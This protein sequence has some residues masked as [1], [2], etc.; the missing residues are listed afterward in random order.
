MKVEIF[1][2]TE[3]AVHY[4]NFQNKTGKENKLRI[5]V[6]KTNLEMLLKLMNLILKM[7]N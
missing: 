7:V 3:R 2:S 1:C 4:W 6:D 5:E